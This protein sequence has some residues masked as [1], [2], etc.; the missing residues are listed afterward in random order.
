MHSF[1]SLNKGRVSA[2]LLA[3]MI[4]LMSNIMVN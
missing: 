2:F 4:L 3:I 1:E